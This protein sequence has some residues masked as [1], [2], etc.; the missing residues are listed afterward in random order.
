VQF[1]MQAKILGL[2][3]LLKEVDYQE[4]LSTEF[5]L[6]LKESAEK[7]QQTNDHLLPLSPQAIT[8]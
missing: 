3:Q 1:E 4:N 5:E 2:P 7:A 8:I 6:Q